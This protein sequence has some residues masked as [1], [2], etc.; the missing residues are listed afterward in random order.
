MGRALTFGAAALT[1]GGLLIGARTL[2]ASHPASRLDDASAAVAHA[3][4]RTCV[5]AV[6]LGG[7]AAVVGAGARLVA[8]ALAFAADGDALGPIVWV[9]LR[10]TWGVMALV[11]ALLGA[12]LCGAAL[13]ARRWTQSADRLGETQ[14]VYPALALLVVPA[15]MGHAAA[16]DFLAVGITVDVLHMAG[17][18]TWAG[19]VA[20]LAWCAV[21]PL[22][23]PGMAALITAFH[24]D[25]VAAVTAVVLSGGIAAWRRL[26]DPLA[27]LSTPYGQVLA[28]KA[29]LVLPVLALGWWNAR[30]GPHAIARGATPRV[31]RAL[32]LE[33][34]LFAAVLGLTA[35][36]TGMSPGD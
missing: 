4:A 15:F 9:I 33:V 34:A 19:G 20:L 11:Q 1:C 36:L 32:A 21:R 24:P 22:S 25:A 35:I 8:Q 10:T 26:P 5:H 29:A 23:R 7:A 14:V 27:P 6:F 30:R 31:A 18:S 3:V 2:R 13:L 17:A 12:T 28:L 16:D